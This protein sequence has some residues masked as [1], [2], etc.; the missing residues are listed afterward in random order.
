MQTA[1]NS[2]RLIFG[3]NDGL[4]GLIVDVYAD[5]AVVQLHY[6]IWIPYLEIVL[7]SIV[8]V[9][10]PSSIVIRLNRLMQSIKNNPFEDGQVVYGSLANEVVVFNEH[11]IQFSANVIKG[12]KTG[13]FLD[14]RENR[15]RVGELSKNKTV[16][17]VFA[18]AG[19]FSVHALVGGAKMVTSVDISKPWS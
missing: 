18:Y 15:K 3:E 10:K 14:H 1:T 7:E 9:I 13:Y 5:V 6:P 11:G 12:H 8:S 2:Y 4:P 17:D 19:G 16:L